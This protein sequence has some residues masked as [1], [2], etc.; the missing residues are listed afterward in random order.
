MRGEERARLREAPYFGFLHL[1]I[2]QIA[3]SR[4]EEEEI[5]HD[6][7]NE[8]EDENSDNEEGGIMMMMIM[9]EGVVTGY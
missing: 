3:A 7:D 9:R 6:R 2:E 4:E 8:D 5:D 1:L